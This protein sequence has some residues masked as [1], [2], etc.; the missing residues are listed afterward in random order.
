VPLELKRL[1]GLLVVTWVAVGCTSAASDRAATPTAASTLA[2]GSMPS[3]VS[4]TAPADGGTL[5]PTSAAP[6]TVPVTVP[7]TAPPATVAAACDQTDGVLTTPSGRH[8][9]VRAKGVAPGSPLVFII[10]G[11][12][13]TPTGIEKFAEFTAMANAA[14]VAVAYPEGTPVADSDGFGWDSGSG[15]F[16]TSGVDD[17]AALVEMFDAVIATGCVDPAAITLSGESNGAAITLVALCDARLRDRITSAVMVIPAVDG[18]VLA[19][20]S[21]GGR[22]LPLSV[23]TGLLDKTAPYNGGRGSLLPQEAWF[24]QAAS[25]VN[26]CAPGAPTREQFDA[27]AQRLT[28]AGCAACTEMFA[29]DDGT[30]TWPGTSRGVAGLRPGTFDLDGR[31]LSLALSRTPGCLV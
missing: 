21:P 19:H 26:G 18:G 5:A 24:T 23:V 11:Y 15:I 25:L 30:H 8:V 16:S 3:A 28:P 22:P 4:T 20:C 9:L 7:A 13:G 12:T 29:I 1:I 27:H 17:V 6:T 2:L 14:S 31:L 10:H